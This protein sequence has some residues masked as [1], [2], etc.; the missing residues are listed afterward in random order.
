[1]I[2]TT[3]MN[4]LILATN[5]TDKI[6]EI[7]DILKGIEIS[8]YSAQD[9]T[10]FPGVE[11]TGGTLEENALLKAKAVFQ[12]YGLPCL[13]D[14]T[15]LEVEHLGGAPGVL[16]ARFAGQ[17][18]SYEDNYRKLLG[19]LDGVPAEKRAAIFRTVIAF[20]DSDG[21]S[22]TVVGTL[23]GHIAPAPRGRFG[24]GYDPVFEVDG[25]TLAE[26]LPEE[27][28]SISHRGIALRKIK[29]I[30]FNEYSR[31]VGR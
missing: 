4:K 14:D 29:P 9:L 13:A 17:G 21:K 22:H 27:K 31:P 25:R 6:A 12:S 8:I 10:D 7:G 3:S 11:E 26:M 24:F 1:M 20:I 15:G 28:N 2:G 5:N 23:H 18:C 16:S 19:L 30:L